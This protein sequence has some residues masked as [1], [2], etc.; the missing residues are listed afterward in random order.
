MLAP[1]H[2]VEGDQVGV[3]E[4]GDGLGLAGDLAFLLGD[5]TGADDLYRHLAAEVPVLGLVDHA[6]AAA[7]QLPD[8]LEAA[9]DRA[10]RER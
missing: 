2:L 7:P 3:G 9:D 1:P 4:A 5:A 6:E 10:G 8:D